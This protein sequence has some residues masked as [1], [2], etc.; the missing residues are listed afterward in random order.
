M[1]PFKNEKHVVNYLN[2]AL[3]C[4]LQGGIG[5]WKGKVFRWRPL[6]R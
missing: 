6:A 4:N 3:L 5:T 1:K 2:W